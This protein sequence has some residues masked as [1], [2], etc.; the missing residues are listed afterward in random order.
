MKIPAQLKEGSKVV[1]CTFSSPVP[2]SFE[3]RF[4]ECITYFNLK[5]VFK[6]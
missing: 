5:S 3:K 4:N 6:I 1:I 2:L